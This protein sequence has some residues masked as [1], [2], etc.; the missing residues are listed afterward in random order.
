M[1]LAWSEGWDGVAK[2]TTHFEPFRRAEFLAWRRKHRRTAKR[3]AISS[4]LL[5]LWRNHWHCCF[6]LWWSMVLPSYH[7]KK[8]GYPDCWFS[9]VSCRSRDAAWNYA[10]TSSSH[11]LFDLSF[12]DHLVVGHDRTSVILIVYKQITMWKL[13]ISSLLHHFFYYILAVY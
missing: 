2:G 5:K 13:V 8:I 6:I 3:R 1:S 12:T 11:A 9:S 7:D 10:S 4:G